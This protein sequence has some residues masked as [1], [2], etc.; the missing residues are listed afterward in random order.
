MKESVHL[1]LNSKA[2]KDGRASVLIRVSHG[3]KGKKRLNTGIKVKPADFNVKARFARWIKASDSQHA[4]KNEKLK[5]WIL[6]AESAAFELEKVKIEPTIENIINYLKGNNTVQSISFMEFYKQ[7]LELMK[8]SN[9]VNTYRRNVTSYRKLLKYLKNEPL[10]FEDINVTFLRK[11]EQYLL[12]LKHH[13]NTIWKEFSN[14]RSN[15]S[16]GLKTGLIPIEKNPFLSFTLRKSKVFKQKLKYDEIIKIENLDLQPNSLLDL[17]RDTFIGQFY[18]MGIRFG[19]LARLEW[20]N[21]KGDRIIYTMNKTSITKSII[22]LPQMK[23]LLEKYKKSNP[24][25][26][27]FPLLP[28]HSEEL[29]DFEVHRIISNKNA[30]INRNLKTIGKLINTPISICTHISRHSLADYLRI[31]KVGLYEISHCLGHKNLK[32]TE[33]YLAELDQESIDS[34]LQD[35]F[36]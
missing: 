2:N 21:I 10:Y 8:L 29:N 5:N 20:S 13:Q 32:T 27:I 16:K 36:C 35:L 15:F 1:E 22:I 9:R 34:S 25:K 24:N 33:N 7:E 19:D 26:H 17:A 18:L 6:R 3:R 4:I 23:N 30:I 12:S 11:Y 28:H 31:K 14:I